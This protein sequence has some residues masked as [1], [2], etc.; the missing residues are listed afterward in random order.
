MPKKL[1]PRPAKVECLDKGHIFW[2]DVSHWVHY[3]PGSNEPGPAAMANIPE[4]K[5]WCGSL[6][7]E[8]K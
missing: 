3:T 6:S 7:K 5:C 4:V 1:E 8:A 2:K